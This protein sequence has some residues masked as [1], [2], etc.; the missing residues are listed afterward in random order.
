VLGVKP[1]FEDV[2]ASGFL[3]FP[4]AI[5]EDQI[6]PDTSYSKL[7]GDCFGI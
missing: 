2:D 1:A 3:A 6:E 5:V 4:F 7:F